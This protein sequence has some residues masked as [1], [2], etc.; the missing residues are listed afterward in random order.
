M[1][2]TDIVYL[3]RIEH[4]GVI[5][6]NRP[7]SMNAINLQMRTMLTALVQEADAD[8]DVRVIVLRGA[9]ERAFSAGADV[10]EFAGR[11]SLDEER[12]FREPPNWND[13]LA[14]VRKP[15]LAA[16]RGF[17]LGGGLEIALAC[18]IRIATDDSLFGLPEVRLAII[19]GAG[20]TQRLPRVVGVAHALRLI[21]TG[22]RID[23]AEALQIGLIS[24]T[25]PVDGFQARVDSWIARLCAGGP[26]A[27]AYAKEAIQRGSEMSIGDGRR[28][29]ADLATLLTNT[30]DRLEG[31][32]AFRE[33]R[34]PNYTGQ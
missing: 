7:D 11:E 5:T 6:L 29:E 1:T 32:A 13:T 17:C 22:D 3:E 8:P 18:D 33:H 23:A 10:K 31:A 27:Q 4:A 25:G 14:A 28:L 30:R 20:G 26:L 21:L 12:R 16:I 34:A 19:P 9:G 24:E 15:T 2:S